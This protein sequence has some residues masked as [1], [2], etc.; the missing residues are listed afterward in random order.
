MFQYN[1]NQ[2]AFCASAEDLQFLDSIG[3]YS[4]SLYQHPLLE[5]D[6]ISSFSDYCI[7][8][9]EQEFVSS[10]QFHI[11]NG[12]LPLG[13]APAFIPEAVHLGSAHIDKTFFSRLSEY[14]VRL[15]AILKANIDLYASGFQQNVSSSANT[16][17]W[18]FHEQTQQCYRMSAEITFQSDNVRFSL[19]DYVEPC[20]KPE[21][22]ISGIYALS[23]YLVPLIRHADLD[24]YAHAL[25]S[26]YYSES[27][28]CAGPVDGHKLAKRLGLKIQH[29]TLTKEGSISGQLFFESATIAVYDN[30]NVQFIDIPEK[31]IVIDKDACKE[32]RPITR[33]NLCDSINRTI[34]HECVHYVYHRY[35]YFVQH[36]SNSSIHS[37]CCTTDPQYGKDSALY[38][39][40]WQAE[41]ISFRLQMPMQSFQTRA[42]ELLRRNNYATA[43]FHALER[44]ISK[45]A[46]EFHV[47]KK[48]AKSRMR[49]L[50]YPVD[51]VLNYVDG[52][53]IPPFG[54]KPLG[55]K[56]TLTIG[57]MDAARLM[58]KNSVFQETVCSGQYLFIENH[59]CQ[60]RS[61]YIFHDRSKKPQ[62]TSYA[63]SHMDECCLVFTKE[64]GETTYS[65]CEGAL[66]REKK[67]HGVIINFD[68]KSEQARKTISEDPVSAAKRITA[69]LLSAPK[70]FNETLSFH[71][72]RLALTEEAL[73]A[74]AGISSK[75]VSRLCSQPIPK[76]T[77]QTLVAVCIGMH[78]DPPIS[79]D[80]IEK[81]Y[82]PMPPT[83]EVNLFKVMLNTMYYAD[84]YICNDFL[85]QNGF[86]PLS[87]GA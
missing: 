9:Y 7:D 48:A 57:L 56:Q 18:E 15:D 63:R 24:E 42:E 69:L 80:L 41:E 43:A 54:C 34:L 68:G 33:S 25:L 20:D 59:F 85:I 6:S 1:Y 29:H 65:Y 82:V 75:T 2:D 55:S 81:S 49:T 53:Y 8:H 31:T 67:D 72:D 13:K 76:T 27:L 46:A 23:D 60:N 66:K 4:L 16:D 22:T 86:E 39:I 11:L 44:T 74:A 21:P 58:Q 19:I 73:A 87:K 30:G 38:W 62:L 50:G 64:Y 77:I 14:S 45:L 47:S 71:M 32:N 37:L 70:F 61:K 79:Y 5:K 35:F 12:T 78:L 84:I 51:G 83:L 36:L 17:Y 3:D 40:E 10:L 26:F 28:N 52:K